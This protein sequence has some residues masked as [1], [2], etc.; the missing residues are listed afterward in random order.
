MPVE[1]KCKGFPEGRTCENRPVPAEE[2]CASCKGRKFEIDVAGLFSLLGYAVNLNELISGAQTDLVVE[3]RQGKLGYSSIVECKDHRDK[4][5]NADVERFWGRVASSRFTKGYFVSRNGFTPSAKVFASD[6]KEITLLTYKELLNSLADF[7]AY[8]QALIH[9]FEHYSEYGEGERLP[10]IEI[11]ARCD[12]HKY[13]VRLD[14]YGDEIGEQPIDD[15]VLDWL[16]DPKHNYLAILGDYGTGKSSFCL[17]LAYM[18][19]RKYSDDPV[20]NRVPIMVPLRDYTKAVDIRQLVTNLLINQYRIKLASYAAFEKLLDSGR[21]VLLLDGFDEMATKVDRKVTIENF[22]ELA[23]LARPATKTILTCR[24]HY[25]KTQTEAASLLSRRTDTELMTELRQRRTFQIAFLKEFSS[26]QIRVFLQKHTPKWQYLL[27]KIH[28][29]YNL[30]DLA[31]RPILLDIIVKTLPKMDT[32][33]EVINPASLYKVYTGFWVQHEDWRSSMTCEEKEFFTIELAYLMFKENIEQVHFSQLSAPVKQYFRHRIQSHTDLDYFDNDVR[34]CSFLNRDAVGNYRFIHKSFMEYFVARRIK[35]RESS[36]LAETLDDT[37][38]TQEICYFLKHLQI[39]TTQLLDIV[40]SAKQNDKSVKHQVANAISALVAQGYDFS[41]Y[42][43]SG[44]NLQGSILR[45][46]TFRRAVFGQCDLSKA[47]AQNADMKEAVF[48]GTTMS[49]ADFSSAALVGCVLEDVSA[50]GSSF[51]RADLR[52]AR[53]EKVRCP[54]ATFE[55]ANLNHA[56]IADTTFENVFLRKS[57]LRGAHVLDSHFVSCTLS[58]S[59]AIGAVFERTS[60]EETKLTGSDFAKSQFI[61]CRIE[62][63]SLN[64]VNL[65]YCAMQDVEFSEVVCLHR[66]RGNHE[67]SLSDI[68]GVSEKEMSYLRG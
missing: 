17:N 7:S 16:A 3:L 52:E 36:N 55:Y 34:T 59:R 51:V 20:G 8:I 54:K 62:K 42:D 28:S 49:E 58:G 15:F 56:H 64:L 31:K 41:E 40:E 26:E 66:I 44:L 25:F 38:L 33:V 39:D 14:C 53:L 65:D 67:I 6:K 2:L 32:T 48:R 45:D 29:T 68:S 43:F 24:T 37:L 21:I 46:G 61:K 1:K 12:L 9:D 30:Q 5:S 47:I 11:M 57:K 13:Y 18:L 60:L 19:A 27:R 23:K 63:C 50:E 4:I 22:R 35:L 10:I